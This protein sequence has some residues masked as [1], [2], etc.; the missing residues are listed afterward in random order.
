MPA[1]NLRLESPHFPG[2]HRQKVGRAAQLGDRSWIGWRQLEPL[3]NG[4]MV[5]AELA[6]DG[7]SGGDVF[8]QGMHLG[9]AQGAPRQAPAIALCICIVL[10]G[11][12]WR[13]TQRTEQGWFARRWRD[14]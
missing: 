10:V 8:V 7:S 1:E 3:P 11:C 12:G 2:H 6:A 5:D 9:N 13:A 4:A 14:R